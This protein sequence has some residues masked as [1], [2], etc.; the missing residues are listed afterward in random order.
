VIPRI[1]RTRNLLQFGK[2]WDKRLQTDSKDSN[3]YNCCSISEPGSGLM[4]FLLLLLFVMVRI[5][6]CFCF[7]EFCFRELFG[8][9]LTDY[10]VAQ[11]NHEF[12]MYS[13]W[14]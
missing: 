7:I 5:I 8:F 10:C 9:L 14:S 3:I 4:Y 6:L 12:A 13:D 2:M 1:W 11:E